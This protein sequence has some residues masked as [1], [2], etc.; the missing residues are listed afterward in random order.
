MAVVVQIEE[1]S[2][3]RSQKFEGLLIAKRDRGV[4]TSFTLRKKS[5]GEGVERTFFLNSPNIKSIEVL[6]RGKVR[7]GKLYY[8]RSLSAKAGRIAEKIQH[9][10]RK[11][12]AN[13]DS[14]S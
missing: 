10:K 3:V 6:R 2:K 4:N 13:T 1:G 12:A 14:T 9:N 7:R 11:K 8:L 5:Y